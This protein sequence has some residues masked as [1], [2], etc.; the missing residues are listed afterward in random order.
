MVDWRG[1]AMSRTYVIIT[2]KINVREGIGYF[3]PKN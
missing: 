2:I 1:S 3:K